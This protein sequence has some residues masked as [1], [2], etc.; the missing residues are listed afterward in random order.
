MF[1]FYKEEYGGFGVVLDGDFFIAL[2]YWFLN[3]EIWGDVP[4]TWIWRVFG[5][6][7]F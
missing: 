3:I 1:W 4:C 7:F 5:A 6:L 2:L